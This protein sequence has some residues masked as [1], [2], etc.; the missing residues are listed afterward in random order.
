MLKCENIT[1][2]TDAWSANYSFEIAAGTWL[3]IAGPSGGGKSTL[4]NIIAGFLA[5]SGGH[6]SSSNKSLLPLPPHKRGVSYMFQHNT[7]LPHLSSA[8]NLALALHDSG[9][10]PKEI[11]TATKRI[12]DVVRLPSTYLSKFPGEL[13][14][15]ELARMNLARAMLRKCDWL[16]LDEPFAAVDQKN[17]SLILA[18]LDDWRDRTKSGILLVSHDITD[19]VLM[20]DRL[21]F[22]S[23]GQLQGT[24]APQEA[25]TS[26]PTL[27]IARSMRSG[28]IITTEHA[29]FYL[30]ITETYTSPEHL[31]DT[32][33]NI[34]TLS[35]PKYR[36][37]I[38]GATKVII[39]RSTGTQYFL[40]SNRQ[41][42]GIICYSADK[43]LLLK[44]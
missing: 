9:Q 4:L 15:G 12:L 27:E 22:I 40:P 21:A 36:S 43:L 1:Y 29:S 10:S 41:F 35:I 16:L 39:D 33:A 17:R 8:A 31:S 28:N 24:I 19:A 20:A 5:P 18:A 38:V 14:G 23:E 13:S 3:G 6:L 2:K 32:A 26:P 11:Q 44:S 37:S 30:P 34:R 25:C 7:L 42:S